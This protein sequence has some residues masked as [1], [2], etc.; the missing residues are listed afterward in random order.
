MKTTDLSRLA[1]KAET[2]RQLHHTGSILLLPN[3]W[4]VMTARLFASRG[5]PA[6][7]TTSGGIAWARG[8]ADGEAM[9]LD[10]V[11]TTTYRM[12]EGISCPLTVDFEGGYAEDLRELRENVQ[13]IIR[14]GAAGINLEDSIGSSHQLREISAAAER[15]RT[16]RS[17]GELLGI[18]LV[19]NARI[20]VWLAGFGN[21][22]NAR[23]EE[24]VARARAYLDAGADCV[25]PIL[26][27]DIGILT[28]LVQSLQCPINVNASP[29]LPSLDE[30]NRIGIARVS[31]AT[32]LTVHA[33]DA[34][35]QALEQIR[36]TGSFDALSPSLTRQKLQELGDKKS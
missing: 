23:F 6:V 31:T 26:L 17:A 8:Y 9:P 30:L 7:A 4:D 22:D 35:L 13:N 33:W 10:L 3:A 11:Y 15:I 25:Y 28:R 27:S 21:D 16:A 34:T 5:F 14:A 12:A 19:I 20:D 29:H 32:S 1:Q 36:T 18:P 24:T 2:L